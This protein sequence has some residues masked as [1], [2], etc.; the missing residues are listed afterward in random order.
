MKPFVYRL[1]A[2]LACVGLAVAA[3][4][5]VPEQMPFDI[6][7]GTSITLEQA[8][9]LIAAAEAE[10]TKHNWKMNIAVVGPSGDLI[11]FARMDGAQLASIEI[12]QA[13]AR[14]AARFRRETRIFAEIINGNPKADPP[15]PPN[16][17]VATLQGVVGSEGGFPLV[18]GGKL[19]G[20]IGCSGGLAPQDGVTCKAG[21]GLVK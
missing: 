11:A 13:K 8:Q 21:A 6:P 7:Y 12:A 16:P 20:A 3:S 4:A 19:I 5:Q 9:K 18:E 15:T 14:A 10:A 17:S 2:T 1:A